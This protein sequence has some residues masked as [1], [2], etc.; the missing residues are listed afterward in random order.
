[1]IWNQCLPWEC[2]LT[3]INVFASH[4]CQAFGINIPANPT[5]IFKEEIKALEIF[6][7]TSMAIMNIKNGSIT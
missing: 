7:R 3:H 5:P 6:I 4:G 2:S 1:M